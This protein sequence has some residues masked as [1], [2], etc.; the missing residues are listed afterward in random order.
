M[1]QNVTF[2]INLKVDGKDVV[3]KVSMDVDEL[4]RVTDAATSASRNL[5]AE[6][7]NF[8]QRAERIRNISESVSQLSD[9][10]NSLTEESR[11]FGGAMAA[12]NTMAGKSGEEFDRLK[13]KV[14][15]L[16]KT[17]PVARDELANGL[18]QVISNGVPEDNWIE[19]LEKSSKASVGGIADL[20][21]TVKVTSTMIKNYGLEW[22]AAGEIQDKIQLTAKN[23][24]T[25]F[26]QMAQALPRVSSQ[27][28]NLGVGIDELMASFATLT[29]VSGNTAEVSTQLAA[30]FTA[31]IKRRARLR[32]W[33]SRW[34]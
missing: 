24:V 30:I 6:L 13:E 11:S 15:D 20:G 34:G 18:Y 4:R 31:L 17:V 7:V 5:A 27:A 29:G 26:E 32:R 3:R 33:R 23:G 16:S 21:E 2:N 25:S 19:F 10:L 14:A 22:D 28:S 1:A 9:T 8:N 12:A